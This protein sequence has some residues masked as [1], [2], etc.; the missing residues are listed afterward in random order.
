MK[1]TDTMLGKYCELKVALKLH[2]LGYK[3]YSS[4]DPGSV[5]DF[6]IRVADGSWKTI[7]VK[8]AHRS[9]GYLKI[10]NS[11]N[12][13]E[14]R[15][16]YLKDQIDY[17]V[18][19]DGEDFYVFGFIPSRSNPSL[20]SLGLICN[21]EYLNRFDLIPAPYIQDEG[22][23]HAVEERQEQEGVQ[24]ERPGDGERRA[25]VEAESGSRVL[26]EETVALRVA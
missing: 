23:N 2:E 20:W 4:L 22:G 25:L 16:H 26:S 9:Q 5:E 15:S 8:K 21:P 13:T 17:I 3:T 1:Q 19:V 6:M 14:N 18:G 7:Q 10:A 12:N 24:A 11:H